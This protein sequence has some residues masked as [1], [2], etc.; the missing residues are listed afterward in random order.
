MPTF[1]H[2]LLPITAVL[3]LTTPA[4]AAPGLWEVR[5]DDSVI[6]VFGS[7]PM[8]PEKA[9]W[10]TA[11]FDEKLALSDIVVF[12]MDFQ[13]SALTAYSAEAFVRGVYTDGT[14]LTNLLSPEAVVTLKELSDQYNFAMGEI[15]AARPWYAAAWLS[16]ESSYAA[17]LQ[18]WGV[19]SLLVPEL[20]SD[21]MAYL[22]TASDVIA[23][24]AD[25]PI[26]Q[27]LS[28]LEAILADYDE[29]P[30]VIED[31]VDGWLSGRH[32]D[33][34]EDFISVDWDFTDAYLERTLR[35]P[36]RDWT[37]KLGV[38]LGENVQ[39]MV[40][41]SADHVTGRSGVL[42]MLEDAG[43]TVERIQ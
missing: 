29:V 39:A 8:L 19:E 1:R 20:A 17:G 30:A 35:A 31:T 43:Y 22:S 14:L 2:C 21:R 32:F 41:V 24:E 12:E 38:M 25:V 3:G 10:Q 6:W 9:E 37:A 13:L 26:E 5:D 34:E 16:W 42:A 27:Q 23:Q 40:I 18:G 4:L 33:I 15:I 7:L 11:L 28:M 36:N